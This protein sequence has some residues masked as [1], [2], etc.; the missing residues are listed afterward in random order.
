MARILLIDD[1]PD[2]AEVVSGP[3]TELG[4]QVHYEET[5]EEA[6]RLL[7]AGET[8]DL[9]L[10]DNLMPRMNG[11]E[12]LDVRR[13]RGWRVPV[14]LMTGSHQDKTA[15]EA[16]Q[17][18][19]ADYVI[20][21]A[22]RDRFLADLMPAINKILAVSRRPPRVVLP[23]EAVETSALVGHSPEMLKVLKDIGRLAPLDETVLILG[24]TGSGKELVAE[25]LWTYHP[26]R[27][28]CPFIAV[29]CAALTNPELLANELFGHVPGAFTGATDKVHKGL[30]EHA[31]GGTLFLDEAGD[32]PLPLQ[33]SLLRVL[34]KREI[35][36]VGSSEPIAVDVRVIAATLRDLAA[37]VREEK[38]RQDLFFRLAGMTIR[39]PP[40]RDRKED[41][42]LLASTF[43][44]RLFPSRRDRPTLDPLALE[45]LR[46]YHWPGNV[47][48]LQKVMLRAAGVCHDMH[49]MPEDIDFG[50]AVA[51][52]GP[53]GSPQAVDPRAA[54]RSLIE[55]AWRSGQPELWPHLR[56]QLQR[57]LLVFALAQ[58][59]L[60]KV[61]LAKR[62]GCAKGYLYKQLELF[63]L[64]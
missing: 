21:S 7:S 4:H 5:A 60:S 3:L 22:N 61:K 45:R 31:Q 13:E 57:E 28:H 43:L 51:A 18:G 39:V 59:G 23:D 9:I 8:F 53:T 1:D 2:F 6:F 42:E 55:T 52:P 19:A 37:L 44:A 56:D 34:D 48:E 41:I 47:R 17:R 20:K 12:F 27:Q 11:M 35:F 25:A 14:I 62:L 64:A 63:G 32:M 54:L 49:I 24:E 30:F 38:F 10:L 26:T 36:R 58:P 15:I 16:P 46:A 50:E 29:N 40:L 33:A